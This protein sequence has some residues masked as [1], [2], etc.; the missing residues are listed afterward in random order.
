MLR[1]RGALLAHGSAEEIAAALLA[2][3]S[4]ADAYRA[5]S[6]RACAWA[7]QYS[8]EGLQR[9]LADLLASWWRCPVGVPPVETSAAAGARASSATV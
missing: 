3:S 1:D 9:S 6:Q 7:R 8:L 2:I 5:D 4:D